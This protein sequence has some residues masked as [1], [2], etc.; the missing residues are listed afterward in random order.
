MT[1]TYIGIVD[2]LHTWEVRDENGIIIGTNQSAYPPCPGDGWI[3]D[4][5]N[6]IWIEEI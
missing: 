5:V 2:G 4:E 6:C 1:T 3:L